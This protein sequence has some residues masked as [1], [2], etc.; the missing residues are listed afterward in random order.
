MKNLRKFC[1][2]TLVVFLTSFAQTS[3]A[4]AP[5]L[6][7]FKKNESYASVRAKMIKAG[8]KPFHSKNADTCSKGDSRCEG[9]PEMA[10]C[11]GTGM[12][13]CKF[14]WKKNGKITAICTVGEENAT[15]DGICTYP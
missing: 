3:F 2:G 9:R 7:H 1:C 10:A 5:D 13:N 6:P 8:W 15:Y 12:A 14:L 4:Q 11:A